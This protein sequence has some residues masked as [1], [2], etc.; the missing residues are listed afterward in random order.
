MRSTILPGLIGK[1]GAGIVPTRSWRRSGGFTLI[2]LLVVIAII[3]ILIGLLLPAVQKVREEANRA[4][5]EEDLRALQCVAREYLNQHQYYPASLEDLAATC[6]G[7][8]SDC[9]GVVLSIALTGEK[10]GHGFEVTLA[11]ATAWAATATPVFPGKTGGTTLTIDQDGQ[12]V[13][14]LTPGAEEAREQMFA[15]LRINA[16]RVVA[17][18]STASEADL[19]EVRDG[20]PATVEDWFPKFDLDGD[21]QVRPAEVFAMQAP[22]AGEPADALSGFLSLARQEMALGAGG[23]DVPALT[24]VSVDEITA[25]PRDEIARFIGTLRAFRRGDVNDDG[26]TDISDP[27][28]ALGFLFLGAPDRLACPKSTDANDDGV[29]DISDPVLFLSNLFLG[30]H[31][32]PEP[33]ANCA[34]DPTADNLPCDAF[35][36][37]P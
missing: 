32:I 11:S 2:E 21:H 15:A 3:A 28:A 18:L 24:G 31:P 10:D 6:Q 37:C 29:I 17:G 13:A 19:A 34:L 12:I 33:F 30:G 5:C 26:V 16:L 25:V 20:L 35:T 9:C 23:E 1:L 14:V 4:R 27:I 36:Y 7:N 8:S 22:S